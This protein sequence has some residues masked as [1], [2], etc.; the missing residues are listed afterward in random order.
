MTAKPIPRK[1]AGGRPP[2][3]EGPRRPIT[4]TLPIATLNK[5]T[6]L[7]KDRAKAIVRA[8]DF[9][10]AKSENSE[11]GVDVV[12]AGEDFG[13]I[14]VRPTPALMSIPWLKLVEVSPG[15]CLISVPS[16]TSLERIELGIADA[17]D[18][19]EPGSE[20]RKLLDELRLRIKGLRRAARVTHSE[21]LLVDV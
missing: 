7:N 2:K 9:S 3:F 15:R 4:V 20:D 8:V 21:I 18:E 17:A 16:G 12:S 5:L 6:K 10:L 13:V 1:S 11:T 14:L 19:L